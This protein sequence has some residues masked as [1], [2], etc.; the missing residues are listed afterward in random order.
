M[1]CVPCQQAR[2]SA[3]QPRGEEEKD[4]PAASPLPRLDP[5]LPPAEGEAD[6]GCGGVNQLLL[7]K[8]GST[9]RLLSPKLQSCRPQVFQENNMNH[10]ETMTSLSAPSNERVVCQENTRAAAGTACC[11]ARAAASGE[12]SGSATVPAGV[13]CV[14]K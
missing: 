11:H 13:L 5:D 1:Q 4:G 2:L 7:P 9:A 3:A 8:W 14:C 10:M 12:A 6:S